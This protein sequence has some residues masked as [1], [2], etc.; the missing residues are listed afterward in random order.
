MQKHMWS[1]QPRFGYE[2]AQLREI[3]SMSGHT[4]AELEN[5]SLPSNPPEIT[6]DQLKILM[7][8]GAAPSSVHV[9]ALATRTGVKVARVRE[10]CDWG[11]AL[12][13]VHDPG[14]SN[15]FFAHSHAVL[16]FLRHGA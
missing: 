11:V 1:N 3:T 6:D 13:I 2:T 8:L 9:R 7:A 10:I 16:N 12:G 14:W 4:L 15:E 5:M